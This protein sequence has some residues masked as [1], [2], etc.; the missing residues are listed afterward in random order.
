M[1]TVH[2]S[3]S[4]NSSWTFSVTSRASTNFQFLEVLNF[5]PLKFGSTTENFRK[6]HFATR[7]YRYSSIC[8]LL[9]LCFFLDTFLTEHSLVYYDCGFHGYHYDCGFPV[10]LHHFVSTK[11]TMIVVFLSILINYSANFF[12]QNLKIKKRKRNFG[13]QFWEISLISLTTSPF[14]YRVVISYT[15]NSIIRVN[16][17]L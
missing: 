14:W 13:G 10:H 2:V 5:L 16:L 7:F 9:W 4:M 12:S 17:Y 8:I 1:W 15:F 11:Y 6:F 3:K